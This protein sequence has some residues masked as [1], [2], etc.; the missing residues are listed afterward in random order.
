MGVSTQKHSIGIPPSLRSRL[1]DK[2]TRAPNHRFQLGI[3]E[4]EFEG[5]ENI[6]SAPPVNWFFYQ[7]FLRST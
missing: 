7:P 3:S 6:K 2:K 5:A 4:F 1:G